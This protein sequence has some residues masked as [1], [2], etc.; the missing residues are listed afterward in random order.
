MHELSRR[1]GRV[2]INVTHSLA[3]LDLYDSVLVLHEGRIVYH[4]QP[5]AIEHYFGVKDAEEIYPRLTKRDGKDWAE[6]WKKHSID[7]YKGIESAAKVLADQQKKPTKTVI[8]DEG[9]EVVVE[10]EREAPRRPNF[11][12]QI[13]ALLFRRLKIFLRDGGQL[14][15]HVAHPHGLPRA[16]GDIRAGW[17]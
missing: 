1:D 5:R 9:R 16:G 11:I 2:V 7:Y 8:D 13:L 15:L 17:H 3:N 14:F 4:G 6:S 10:V 12:T